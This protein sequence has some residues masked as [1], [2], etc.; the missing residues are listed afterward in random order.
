MHEIAKESEFAVG[1]L[2]KFFANKEDLYKNLLEEKISEFHRILMGAL[3]SPGSEV[4]KIKSW[5]K[6]KIR[7]FNDHDTFV[8]L[9]FTETM[10]ISTNVRA[11]LQ[12]ET[13]IKYEDMLSKIKKIF[14]IGIKKKVFE[15]F[16][17]YHLA[18]ALDGISNA[19]LFEYLEYP[20]KLKKIEPDLILNLFFSQIH[21]NRGNDGFVK[22]RPSGENPS[23]GPS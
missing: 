19:L 12:A 22:S 6:E 3:E 4:E 23:P 8:R 14:E 21:L 13:R 18:V 15:K 2:Y 10:G 17:P 11:G 20:E 9:Y 16:D 7:I 1:T 5:I